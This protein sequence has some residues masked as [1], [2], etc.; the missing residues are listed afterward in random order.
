MPR[1][2]DLPTGAVTPRFSLAAMGDSLTVNHTLGDGTEDFW[3]ERLA[4]GLRAL[5]VPI[6][7]RN[8][9]R[10]GNTTTDM[11]A[12]ISV[13]TQIDTPR[14]A[15]IWGGVNDPGNSITGST[16]Q[17]NIETMGATLLN[18]GVDYLIIGN[19]QYLNFSSSGDTLDTPYASYATLRPYQQAAATALQSSYPG[20]VAFC[21]L[22]AHMRKLI[23]DGDYTQGD[24][25]WHVAD[26]NQHLNAAGE[27][28]VAD[29][30]L[31]TIQAQDG[32]VTA[33]GGTA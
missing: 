6:R 21:D 7:A 31:A 17:S 1:R 33:L 4:V 26:S 27:Q 10:S 29:A 32:W 20:Q 9:G 28:I 11:L 3:P 15:G 18:A 23:V 12:R 22:Y 13:M 16:T 30:V 2:I 14:L 8:Y 5:G 25:L 19:T 24:H